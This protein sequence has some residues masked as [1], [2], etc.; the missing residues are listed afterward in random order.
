MDWLDINRNAIE[1]WADRTLPQFHSQVGDR[2]NGDEYGMAIEYMIELCNLTNSDLWIN[3]PCRASNDYT[4]KLAQLIKNGNSDVAP[5]N[6]SLKVYVEY[7]NEVWNF[8]AGFMCYRWVHDEFVSDIR[9]SQPG[10]AI[11]SDGD[12][13]EFGEMPDYTAWRI[14]EASD[15][16]RTVFGNGAMMSRIRPIL[17]SQIG[18]ANGNYKQTLDFIENY[19]PNPVDYYI[20]GGGGSGYYDATASILLIKMPTLPMFLMEYFKQK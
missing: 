14:A 5:L 3:I 16:F 15:I 8:A 12:Q 10:H 18:N 4:T 13:G 20:Y 6:S 9:A 7:A 19:Y 2:S 11:L 1:N 17:S